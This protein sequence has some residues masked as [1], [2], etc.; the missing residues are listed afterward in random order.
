MVTLKWRKASAIHRHEAALADGGAGL[1]E[2]ELGR[3][4]FQAQRFG[5][6]ADG[7]GADDEHLAAG[8][9]DV[10]GG[11]DD[12]VDAGRRRARRRRA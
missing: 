5:A 2:G 7:P 3:G 1:L 6:E 9:Q 10:D 11:L 8:A 4:L 12:A